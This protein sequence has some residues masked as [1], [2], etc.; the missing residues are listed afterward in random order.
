MP[1]SI[2]SQNIDIDLLKIIH[3]PAVLSSDPLF[4]TISDSHS[5]VIVVVPLTLGIAGLI[6]KDEALFV[7]AVEIGVASA[8]NLGVTHLLKYSI[9]R[10]R[11]YLIYPSDILKKSDGDSGSFPSGHTSAAFATATSLSLNFPKWYVIVPSYLWAGTVG[12]S[13]MYLGMHYPSDVLAGALLGAGSA[14][15]TYKVNHWL[16]TTYKK[17]YGLHF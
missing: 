12:Y 7:K 9:N 17:N 3:T 8:V 16:Q 5:A 13:R 11:P 4:R 10:P 2:C 6:E 1:I 15:L 14:W